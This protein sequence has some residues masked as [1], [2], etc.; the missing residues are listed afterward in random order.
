MRPRIDRVGHPVLGSGLA[1][2]EDEQTVLGLLPR[3][4]RLCPRIAWRVWGSRSYYLGIT[5]YDGF[6]RTLSQDL[7][8]SCDPDSVGSKGEKQYGTG[9]VG[10][11][12]GRQGH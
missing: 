8:C 1:T 10:L 7:Q 5:S 9:I 2:G 4:A 11:T 3:I 6:V 12:S